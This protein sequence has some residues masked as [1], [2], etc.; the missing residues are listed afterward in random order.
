MTDRQYHELD[1]L[2]EPA[3]QGY[4]ARVLDSPVGQ[5]ST[6]FKLPFSNLE[7]ENFV[8]RLGRSRGGARRI[9][10]SEMAAAKSF[11]GALFSA[12]FSGDVRSCLRASSDEASRQGVG[13]RM[14][15][16]LSRVPELGDL[17]WEYLYDPALNRFLG[18]S[19]ET[20]IVRYLD[21][22]ERVRALAVKPPLRILVMI[23]SPQDF[24]RLDVDR[25]YDNLRQALAPLVERGLLA[26]DRLSEP[27]L[28]GLQRRLRQG[29]YHVFHFIG[30]G[31][32]D[33]QAEDGVL[34]FE[35]EDGRSR[36]VGAQY[37]GTL[38]HDHR[39]LRLAVLNACEGARGAS[40]DP[41]SGTAQGLVQ[42]GVP[43]VIAMQFEISDEA[44]VTFSQELYS[45]VAAGYPV[46]AALAEARKAIFAQVNELEWGTPVLYMRA[47]D[48]RIST[49]KRPS[50]PSGRP[51][52]RRTRPRLRSL[53][54]HLR[55]RPSW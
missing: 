44:A 51:R 54:S 24:P 21:L 15:L 17:P 8:L 11:G 27:T 10:S 2:I 55:R 46:D 26:V 39:S 37:L 48:G 28:A 35:A 14:R 52:P 34:V 20:P 9:E 45:A 18:L 19:A 49:W 5:A 41:F 38:L 47:P 42:Q 29:E 33:R 13:L 40:G 22:P 36:Q 30:H 4:C 31:G 50:S 6:E 1:L 16:H 7:I 12:V 43:A 23:A 25:E 32:F 53:C 3:G